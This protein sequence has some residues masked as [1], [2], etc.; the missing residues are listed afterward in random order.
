M[1]VTTGSR[2][3]GKLE[4]NKLSFVRPTTDKVKQALFTKLQ[5]FIPDKIVLDL[6]CGTGALGIE[7]LSRGAKKVVF[8]DKNYKSIL[9]TKTNLRNLKLEAEV[10]KIDAIKFLQKQTE[11]FDLILI[12][13]PYAS[14]LYEPALKII[15]EKDLL[16]A[17]GI[18]V[19]EHDRDE[20]INSE[21]YNVIDKKRYG[22]TFLTFITK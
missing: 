5:F 12:D 2:R 7:A 9:L 18:I 13:P 10:L 1:R 15:F 3:G 14:K 16:S 19:C 21:I 17:N 11:K 8:V 6:F 4:K 22:N 20:N